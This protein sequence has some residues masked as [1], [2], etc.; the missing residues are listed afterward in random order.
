MSPRMYT[1]STS[2]P[3]DSVCG[4]PDSGWITINPIGYYAVE[5][6]E[7]TFDMALDSWYIISVYTCIYVEIYH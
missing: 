4:S 5:G 2:V 1:R 3:C 6:L 7:G